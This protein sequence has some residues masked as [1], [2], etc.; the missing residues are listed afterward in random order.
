MTTLNHN[1]DKPTLS[2][3]LG[4]PLLVF[5]GLGVT[6]GAGIFALIGEILGIAGDHAPLAFIIAGIIFILGFIL[7]LML[8]VNLVLAS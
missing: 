6:V 5:Y 2:R 4:L 3:A 7:M 8:I 1:P